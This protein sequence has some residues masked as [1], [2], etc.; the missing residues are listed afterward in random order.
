[1]TRQSSNTIPLTANRYGSLRYESN[2]RECNESCNR[3]DSIVTDQHQCSNSKCTDTSNRRPTNVIDPRPENNINLSWRAKLANVPGNANYADI[4]KHGRKI[5]LAGDSIVKRVLGGNINKKLSY[6]K[7]FVRSYV[8]PTVQ[9]VERHLK[10]DLEEQ[11]SGVDTIILNYG[12]NNLAPK[13]VNGQRIEQ[14]EESI[15]KEMIDVARSISNEHGINKVFIC[16]LTLRKDYGQKVRKINHL[17]HL[18][19]KGEFLE[20]LEQDL[21]IF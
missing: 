18:R 17:L 13:W 10:C 19:P 3:T 9:Q 8:G 20:L 21:N 5:C 16:T 2:E 15:V 1:M 11:E 4:A 14:S 12:T 6:G 7:C